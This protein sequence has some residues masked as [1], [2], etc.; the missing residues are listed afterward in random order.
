MNTV[1]AL[2]RFVQTYPK[3]ANLVHQTGLLGFRVC[4][5]LRDGITADS[6]PGVLGLD[7]FIV[8]ST[9]IMAKCGNTYLRTLDSLILA[10]LGF[11][12]G[13]S[14]ALDFAIALRDLRAMAQLLVGMLSN[15]RV[16]PRN[17]GFEDL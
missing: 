4:A 14:A 8:S 16:G 15:S 5:V 3:A 12:D 17:A 7:L 11:V 6:V 1:I 10:R 9:T 13:L 2:Q